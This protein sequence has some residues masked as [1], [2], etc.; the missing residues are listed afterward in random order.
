VA[1]HN[2]NFELS[3][4]NTLTTPHM[5]FH[6]QE[7]LDYY[8]Y[9]N[10]DI[11]DFVSTRAYYDRWAKNSEHL[12][13]LIETH[14]R[15]CT[16]SPTNFYEK[17]LIC[18]SE[19]NS[20]DLADYERNGFV[21][22]YYWNHALTARDWFRFAQHDKVLQPKLNNINH[23]FL[24][25]NRAW[26]GS[27]EYRL[28]FSELLVEKN[29]VPHC[30]TSF[31]A[32]DNGLYYAY[33]Q[34]RNSS[35]AIQNKNLEYQFIK[36]TSE[37]F[38][39]G[40]YNNKDYANCAL[41]VVLETVFDSTKHHLTEKILRPI[42]CRRPFIL[43]ST[44]GSLQ[45]LRSYGFE[46]FDGLIDESYDLEQ[47]PL[48]RLHAITN[49]MQRLCSLPKTSKQ[50]LWQQLYEIAERN[51]ERFFSSQ[52]FDQVVGEYKNNLHTALEKCKLQMSKYWYDI[53]MQTVP[54]TSDFHIANQW[55]ETH[56]GRLG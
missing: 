14:L 28:K 31:S 45:Y 41:E 53:A 50:K 47:D 48:L 15:C 54:L 56:S 27:R 10:Q 20:A 32:M 25:Y 52:F 19:Q 23:D 33:H 5:F 9:T 22:V 30:Q 42:A 13:S 18:H 35:L 44:Q 11:Q 36:N 37:S 17:T 2:K 4:L 46:T 6:D 38:A 7:P 21:G 34:F 40:D 24:I 16:I 1:L 49:E 12:P 55:Y 26:S 43:A 29:L 8:M 3:Y 51:H 39:S